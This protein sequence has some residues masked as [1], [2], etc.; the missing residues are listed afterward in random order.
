YLL[1]TSAFHMAR[2]V[3]IARMQGVNVIAYPVD[4]RTNSDNLRIFDFDFFDH[5]K[6]LEP[7]WREW[8]G[9]TVYYF[10][11]KTNSWFPKPNGDIE[12]QPTKV[13]KGFYSDEVNKFAQ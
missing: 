11:G 7:A 2:S 12:N 8:I 3:G 13:I 5:L 10:T 4:Y 9:L 6:A 1:V